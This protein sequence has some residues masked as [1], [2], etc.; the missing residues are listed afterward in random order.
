MKKMNW[1][2]TF[3]AMLLGMLFAAFSAGAAELP[4]TLA[5]LKP[6]CQKVMSWKCRYSGADATLSLLSDKASPVS[7]HGF[8]YVVI[9]VMNADFP[10]IGTEPDAVIVRD[11]LKDGHYVIVA[12]FQNH[13]NAKTPDFDQDLR[14]IYQS[15]YQ[16]GEKEVL[17]GTGW[18][19]PDGY[20]VF[21]VPSGYRLAVDIPYYDLDKHTGGEGAKLTMK[22]YNELVGRASHKQFNLTKVEKTC[23]GLGIYLFHRRHKHVVRTS[24][25]Q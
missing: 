13:E 17:H 9:Y 18:I 6:F 23:V 22:H 5:E 7:V 21:I 8:H 24:R 1:M 19:A 12:D 2:R 14:D 25:L 20:R 10:R 3:C 11:L 4:E 15:I 16:K